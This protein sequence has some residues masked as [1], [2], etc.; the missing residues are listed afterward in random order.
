[1]CTQSAKVTVA[2]RYI[3]YDYTTYPCTALE[4]TVMGCFATPYSREREALLCQRG[5]T[6]VHLNAHDDARL[7]YGMFGML[8]AWYDAVCVLHLG[9]NAGAMDRGA[10]YTRA[11][12]VTL[13]P[14]LAYLHEWHHDAAITFPN[15]S[16]Q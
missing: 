3:A 9:S 5:G 15:M 13:A 16:A 1:M 10:F 12:S 14:A 6:S 8:Y 2:G 7:L 11:R 4:T